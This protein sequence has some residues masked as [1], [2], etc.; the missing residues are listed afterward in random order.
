[1]VLQW[2]HCKKK[3]NVCNH[4]FVCVLAA[5]RERCIEAGL[6]TTLVPLL[7][8]PDQDQLLHTG[9]AIGRICFENGECIRAG[10]LQ[11]IH[12]CSPPGTSSCVE[13]L[14]ERYQR[15]PALNHMCNQSKLTARRQVGDVMTRMLKSTWCAAGASFFVIQQS[16]L[17][18]SVECVLWVCYY[19]DRK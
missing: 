5:V 8:S 14:G 2:Y 11:S 19:Q 1:M 10:E 7:N 17:C 4:C 6:V 13:T 9:R 3:K 18:V 12:S 15:C 16:S